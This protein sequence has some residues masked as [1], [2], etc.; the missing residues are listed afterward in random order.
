MRSNWPYDNPP[1]IH[2][3]GGQMTRETVLYYTLRAKYLGLSTP[4]L[5]DLVK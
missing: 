4:I 3:L 1:N 2:L 5:F